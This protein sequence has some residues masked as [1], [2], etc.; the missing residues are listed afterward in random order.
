MARETILVI[1]D[2]ADLR[3][4]F[5]YNLRREGFE[6]A[7]SGSGLEGLEKARRGS[8]GLVLL[9]LMLPDLDGLEVCRRLRKDPLTAALP[10][11]MVTARGAESVAAQ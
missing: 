8:P 5:A 11:I 7:E 3:E 2:E 10:V 6:V 9:D 1:E 4:V